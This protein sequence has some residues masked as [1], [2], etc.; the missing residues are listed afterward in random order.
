MRFKLWLEI[1]EGKEE[2]V[3]NDGPHNGKKISEVPDDYLHHMVSGQSRY[4]GHY[5]VRAKH[6]YDELERRKQQKGT[7]EVSDPNAAL[8]S[9]GLNMLQKRS[10]MP[11]AAQQIETLKR[12]VGTNAFS[13][14]Q[15]V[16]E[17][18][19]PTEQLPGWIA[20]NFNNNTGV[21]AL[22]EWGKNFS[23]LQELQSYFRDVVDKRYEGK[24]EE[25]ENFLFSYSKNDNTE[26]DDKLKELDDINTE[27]RATFDRLLRFVRDAQQYWYSK[28]N[29]RDYGFNRTS[30]GPNTE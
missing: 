29:D 25:I 11:L 21:I 2:P 6:I 30:V 15:Y 1:E 27:W 18:C 5:A 28:I 3:F 26:F 9:V 19:P 13:K 23:G 20:F 7:P 24:H 8:R 4:P 12:A 10:Q 22:W 14:D 17:A 16:S